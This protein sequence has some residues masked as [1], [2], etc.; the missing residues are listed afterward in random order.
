MKCMKISK[1]N[2]IMHL[3]HRPTSLESI[4]VGQKNPKMNTKRRIELDI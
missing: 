1:L 2:F 3:Y 4:S